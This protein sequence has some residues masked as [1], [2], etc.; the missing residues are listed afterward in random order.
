MREH[1]IVGLH[2]RRKKRTTIADPVAPPAP[3]LV[4]R[5]FTAADLDE[6]WCG[7]ITY[8]QV[9]SNWLYGAVTLAAGCGMIFRWVVS[10]GVRRCCRSRCRTRVIVIRRR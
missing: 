4:G 1:G 7:D 2:L 8:I 10:G 6:R 9:G 5:D 3:D